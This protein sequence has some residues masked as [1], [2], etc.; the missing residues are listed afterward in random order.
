[1]SDSKKIRI[2]SSDDEEIKKY[3]QHSLITPLHLTPSEFC[4]NASVIKKMVDDPNSSIKLIRD[5]K[6]NLK[7]KVVHDEKLLQIENIRKKYLIRNFSD[8]YLNI[9]LNN[10]FFSKVDPTKAQLLNT[11]KQFIHSYPTHGLYVYGKVGIGKTYTSIALANEFANQGKTIAFIFVP[12]AIHDIKLGFNDKESKQQ[13][14][15]EYKMKSA[16]VLFLDDI[17]IED[18]P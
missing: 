2:L 3:L 14:E 7:L 15:F 5:E 10:H 12:E 16:D 17:G 4:Q 6:G 8:E 18:V 13:L 11:Y 1:M 9:M